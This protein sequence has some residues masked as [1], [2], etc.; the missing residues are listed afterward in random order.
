VKQNGKIPCLLFAFSKMLFNRP[1]P[2][3][4]RGLPRKVFYLAKIRLMADF[5]VIAFCL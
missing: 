2:D 4:C 1:W 5:G 3:V